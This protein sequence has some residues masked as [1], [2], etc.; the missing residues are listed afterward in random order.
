MLSKLFNKYKNN[1]KEEQRG[2]TIQS[3]PS[4]KIQQLDYKD[5]NLTR[6][7]WENIFDEDSEEF[8]DFYYT[9][10]TG[11]NVIWV[12]K[13][14]NNIIAMLQLNPY[15][16]HLR[17]CIVPAHYI[18]GVATSESHRRKGF[19]RSLML[20]AF[21]QMYD[22]KEPFTYLMPASEAYYRPFNFVTGYYQKS[23]YLDEAVSDN[24]KLSF[25][26]AGEE[27]F[28][29]L[30]KFCEQVLMEKYSVFINR[31]EEYYQILKAQFEAENGGIV[32]A[33]DR[34][35]L[36]GCFMYGE[37]DTIEV[38]EPVC[39]DIYK[40]EF[41]SFVKSVFKDTDKK[42]KLTAIDFVNE[43]ELTDVETKPAIMYRIVAFDI[44]ARY[45]R[46]IEPVE[47]TIRLTDEFIKENNDCFKL[48][49][50][51]DDSELLIP[52]SEPEIELSIEELTHIMFKELPQS[53]LDRADESL[54]EKF[55]KI[56]KFTPSF[57]NE[58]V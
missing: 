49:V 6:S 39:L 29:D 7:I 4:V 21:R 14:D 36:V 8:V 35:V 20:K 3:E 46:A 33:Y 19:M 51:T 57:L 28:K 26:Y 38:M 40:D 1:K 52:D 55:N 12:A 22:N 15:Q 25:K 23:G 32:L 5:N 53:V 54:V 27:D 37:Y 9:Y 31:E 16:I 56:I 2:L 11:N 10:R 48:S 45:I 41:N 24:T 44:F 30:S 18:V 34:N 50:G 42:I 47:L 13:E 43:D 17:Y 58:F